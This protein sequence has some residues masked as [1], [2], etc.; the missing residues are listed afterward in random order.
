MVPC[1]FPASDDQVQVNKGPWHTELLWYSRA[2]FLLIWTDV[3]QGDGGRF[4]YACRIAHE[5]A[6]QAANRKLPCRVAQA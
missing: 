1:T 2:A 3:V 5:A 6:Q 4:R